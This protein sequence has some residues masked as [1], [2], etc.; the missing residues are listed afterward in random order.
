MLK[1]FNLTNDIGW[2]GNILCPFTGN[3]YKNSPFPI[4]CWILF[5]ANST[6]GM[7]STDHAR[8]IYF[9][10]K[11]YRIKIQLFNC[12]FVSLCLWLT[13]WCNHMETI[14]E[15]MSSR[16]SFKRAFKDE[17]NILDLIYKEPKCWDL[18][19]VIPIFSLY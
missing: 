14:V 4:K 7:T 2:N 18:H 13:V 6:D 3:L 19:Y 5:F 16:D 1:S 10:T 12:L 11:W 15:E 9:S 8:M 17:D